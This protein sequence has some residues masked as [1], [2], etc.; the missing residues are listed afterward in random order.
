M[1]KTVAGWFSKEC[2]DPIAIPTLW[3]GSGDSSSRNDAMAVAVAVCEV[4]ARCSK[5]WHRTASKVGQFTWSQKYHRYGCN[6]F[7]TNAS[8][9]D[10]GAPA[11]NVH[12]VVASMMAQTLGPCQQRRYITDVLYGEN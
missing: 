6:Q 11:L 4:E 3:V 7:W 9:I 1:V 5:H 8:C 10:G 2:D 12:V